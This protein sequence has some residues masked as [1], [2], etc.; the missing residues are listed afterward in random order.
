M[1]IFFVIYRKIWREQ[2]GGKLKKIA[3]ARNKR[4]DPGRRSK[5]I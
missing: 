2:V 4:L 5:I 3:I 1:P